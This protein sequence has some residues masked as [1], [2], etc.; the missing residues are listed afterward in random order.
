MDTPIDQVK[1]GK[2]QSQCTPCCYHFS[3]QATCGIFVN[4]YTEKLLVSA[5][6][7]NLPRPYLP[8]LQPKGFSLGTCKHVCDIYVRN[9]QF[10]KSNAFMKHFF[11]RALRL[12][13]TIGW[14]LLTQ[15]QQS[16]GRLAAMRTLTASS[17]VRTLTERDTC[18]CTVSS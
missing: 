9:R 17:S 3:W 18:N 12:F 14:Y 5:K 8:A 13:F 10:I 2:P 1:Q 6:G 15:R 16:R 7:S 4:Y 11:P